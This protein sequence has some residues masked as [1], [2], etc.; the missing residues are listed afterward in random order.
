[1]TVIIKCINVMSS[2]ILK[3]GSDVLE[4]IE[5]TKE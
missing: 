4:K 1:M 2:P 5:R 3:Y